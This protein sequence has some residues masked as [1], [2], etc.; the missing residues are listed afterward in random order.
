[1]LCGARVTD[2]GVIPGIA[3]NLL[4]ERALLGAAEIKILS[5]VD[6]KHSAPLAERALE[7]EDR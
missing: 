4:R 2:Q 3:H 5:D 7:D 1:M 6:V